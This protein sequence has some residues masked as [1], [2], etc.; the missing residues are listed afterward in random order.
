M[1]GGIAFMLTGLVFIPYLGLRGCLLVACLLYISAP[2]LT[3]W[4]LSHGLP[5]VVA[6]YGLLSVCAQNMALVPT[7]LLPTAWFPNHRGKIIGFIQAGFGLSS[8]VFTPIQTF[9]INPGNV[10][11]TFKGAPSIQEDEDH[12]YIQSTTEKVKIV[13]VTAASH[14]PCPSGRDASISMKPYYSQHCH[15]NFTDTM[16]YL[17]DNSTDT[18]K[19]FTDSSVLERVPTACLYIGAVYA[20]I[21]TLGFILAVEPPKET[22]NVNQRDSAPRSSNVRQALRYLLRNTLTRLDFYLLFVTRLFMVVALGGTLGHW[23]TLMLT[24]TDSDH[25]ISVIGSANGVLNCLSRLVTGLLI[26]RFMFRQVMPCCCFFLAVGLSVLVLAAKTNLVGFVFC[27]WACYALGFSYNT[28]VPIQAIKLFGHE[29]GNVVIGAIGL[30][31]TLSFSILGTLNQ[32]FL[33]GSDD[34]NSLFWFFLS[35][36]GF[37]GATVVV[38]ALVSVDPRKKAPEEAWLLGGEAE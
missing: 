20:C 9:L 19:Y 5:Y 33:A 21:L 11:P 32:I 13:N 36:A 38:T 35:L 27:L 18:I 28:T 3:Y 15:S 4:S 23:K 2:L 22:I 25:L 7:F 16:A 24:V 31:G 8:T 26:D 30:S 17:T 29:N 34:V 14:H 10:S 6:S 37:A 12:D 1:A